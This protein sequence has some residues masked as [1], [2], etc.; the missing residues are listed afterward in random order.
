M[1]EIVL[2]ELM[3]FI[4][5]AFANLRLVPSRRLHVA[6]LRLSC[7]AKLAPKTQ[8]FVNDLL[9]I[10][11]HLDEPNLFAIMIVKQLSR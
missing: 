4:K 9:L 6:R 3:S 10:S 1:L 11:F 7:Q 2:F 5:C 8:H